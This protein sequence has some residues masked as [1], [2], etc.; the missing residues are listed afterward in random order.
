MSCF[1]FQHLKL[2]YLWDTHCSLFQKPSVLKVIVSMSHPFVLSVNHHPCFLHLVCPHVRLHQL[3]SLYASV[4]TCSSINLSVWK[5]KHKH[6]Q[7]HSYMHT[8][9]HTASSL[10]FLETSVW[11]LTPDQL[12]SEQFIWSTAGSESDS[13]ALGTTAAAADSVYYSTW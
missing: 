9:A 7:V 3:Q 10:L 6:T 1:I 11:L 8:L 5:T 13:T 4:F 12:P 2:V